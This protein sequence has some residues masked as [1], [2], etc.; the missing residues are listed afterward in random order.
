[1]S[2]PAKI[3]RVFRAIIFESRWILLIFYIGLI[4]TQILYA[5]LFVREIWHLL[6]H[7]WIFDESEMMLAVLG[8]IDIAM[9]ANLMKMIIAGSYQT[10]V[11][12]VPD[13]SSEKHISSGMLKIKMG[14]SIVGVSSIHL[15]KAFI[16]STALTPLDMQDLISKCSI[17]LILMASTIGFAVIEYLHV[18]G[19]VLENEQDSTSP[20][21]H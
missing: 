2:N 16:N 17:H 14:G 12:K 5:G 9:I 8:V 3:K 11:E 18:K 10:F 19:E 1:M 4:I 13:A 20:D 6:R 15:L 21:T 7:F